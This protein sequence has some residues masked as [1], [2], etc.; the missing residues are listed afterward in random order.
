[1]TE[2][3]AE[4]KYLLG[5]D[6]GGTKTEFLL[7]DIDG[8]EIKRVIL[9]AANPVNNGTEHTAKILGDGIAQVCVGVERRKISVFAGIAG[10]IS[11]NN[12]M[13]INKFLSEFSFGFFNNGSDTDNAIENSLKGG[14]GIVVIMG[15]GIVAFSQNNGIRHRIGGWGYLID[16]GGS[17]FT[18]GSD[19]L[20]S[21]FEHYDGRGGSNIIL[22]LI[23]KK[24]NKP[25]K[26]CI[27]DIYSGGATCVASF[28]QTVFE[29][30]RMDDKE[31]EK[32]IDRNTS[33]VA[34]IIRTAGTFV[35][36]NKKVVL[37]GGLCHEEDILKKFLSNRLTNEYRIEF[38]AEP[39]VNGAVALAKANIRKNGE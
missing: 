14:N 1:M 26:D 12:R 2:N 37:C 18:F 39:M 11:G 16:K 27:S 35:S 23:E 28:A 5:I 38:S 13:I 4:I 10:G 17:G 36:G 32:I 19:A 25:L 31:A 22:Q 6:A 34:K 15:T 9:G 21:A 3:N 33:E 8:R 7:T 30:F 29:A 24:L 20:N